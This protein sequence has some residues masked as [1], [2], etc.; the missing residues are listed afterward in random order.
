MKTKLEEA[1]EASA[2]ALRASGGGGK[3]KAGGAASKAGGPAGALQVRS[4]AIWNVFSQ[5]MTAA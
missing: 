3:Q 2:A 4:F 1:Q 5:T